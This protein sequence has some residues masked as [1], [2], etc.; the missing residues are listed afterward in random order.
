MALRPKKKTLVTLYWL[1]LSCFSATMWQKADGQV[2][3][4]FT[5]QTTTSFSTIKPAATYLYIKEVKSYQMLSQCCWQAW[6]SGDFVLI[7]HLISSPVRL[8]LFDCSWLEMCLLYIFL[9][10]ILL[11]SVCTDRCLTVPFIFLTKKQN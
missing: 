2:T 6:C 5:T 7:L 11:Y 1:F 9:D 8:Q 4:F 10:V 3:D